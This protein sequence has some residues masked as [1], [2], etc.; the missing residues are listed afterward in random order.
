MEKEWNL[1]LLMMAGKLCEA[2]YFLGVMPYVDRSRSKLDVLN[3][4]V[5]SCLMLQS[6]M[7][8]LATGYVSD[9]EALESFCSTVATLLTPAVLLVD[10]TFGEYARDGRE[11][12]SGEHTDLSSDSEGEEDDEDDLS[13]CEQFFRSAFA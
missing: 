2:L 8:F 3:W 5:F 7:F 13:A 12:V 4:S 10:F 6:F 1:I 9:S 11:G